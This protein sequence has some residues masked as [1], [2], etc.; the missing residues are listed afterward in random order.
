MSQAAEADEVIDDGRHQRR[1]DAKGQVVAKAK[2][3]AE[4]QRRHDNDETAPIDGWGD[5]FKIRLAD[6]WHA[7]F[8]SEYDANRLHQRPWEMAT[9]GDPRILGYDAVKADEKGKPVKYKELTLYLMREELVQPTQNRDFRR[10]RH[11]QLREHLFRKAR[12]SG[13]VD[14]ISGRPIP[15]PT[16][17]FVNTYQR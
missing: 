1:H 17:G 15:G 10:Q 6:G 13:A 2:E 11:N 14:A 5:P 7:F 12:E 4:P 8:V 16:H 9:W 3:A